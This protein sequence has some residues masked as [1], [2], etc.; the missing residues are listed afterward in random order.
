MLSPNI[1]SRTRRAVHQKLF[2][3]VLRGYGLCTAGAT[4]EAG[5]NLGGIALDLTSDLLM[6]A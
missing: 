5:T 1:T 2:D 4:G 6:G 3:G